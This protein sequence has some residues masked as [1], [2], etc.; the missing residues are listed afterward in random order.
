MSKFFFKCSNCQREV[1]ADTE[2]IGRSAECPYCTT[3]ATIPHPPQTPCADKQ[4]VESEVQK[5]G[6]FIFKCPK[7]RSE[8]K[9]NEKFIGLTVCCQHCSAS[10]VVK[11][12][13]EK[14]A[15]P[16]APPIEQPLSTPPAPVLKK[17]PVCQKEMSS[18]APLCPH[19]GQPNNDAP[20]QKSR[21]VYILLGLFFGGLG[22]HNFYAD[23]SW[24][25][26]HIMLSFGF[27]CA[28][29]ASSKAPDA[30]IVA[31]LIGVVQ[32]VWVI[33]EIC[34]FEKDGNGVPFK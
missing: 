26:A 21:V 27:L 10:V 1:K 7:C 28:I 6:D 33:C 8:L 14:T 22:I 32:T 19:C 17:C 11:P 20:I 12:E 24:G 3:R 5:K 34:S 23:Q 2:W 16:P 13:E 9:G 18:M 31:Y 25:V 4:K 29:A 15:P 30:I